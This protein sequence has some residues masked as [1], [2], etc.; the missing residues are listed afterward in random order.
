MACGL[1]CAAA[2]A[3]LCGGEVGKGLEMAKA[4][5]RTVPVDAALLRGLSPQEICSSGYVVHTLEAAL[6]CLLR[7]GDF[8]ACLLEAVNLGEDAD[9][10]GAVAGGLAG[11]RW[12]LAGIPEEWLAVLA[13]RE[14]I[15]ALC[16]AFVKSF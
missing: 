15:E 16:G 13:G 10:V 6:W 2:N 14:K 8:R 5:Y 11:L 7:A 1:Y 12:G 3:L 4:F 9:T